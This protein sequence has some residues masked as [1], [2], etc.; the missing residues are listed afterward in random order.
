MNFQI[1]IQYEKKTIA[2]AKGNTISDFDN[3][4][5]ELKVKFNEKKKKR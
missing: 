1:K 3:I 2:R 4:L 5:D